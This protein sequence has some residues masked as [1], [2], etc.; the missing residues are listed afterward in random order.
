MKAKIAPLI[1]QGDSSAVPKGAHYF[2]MLDAPLVECDKT[3]GRIEAGEERWRKAQGSALVVR[4]KV[5]RDLA[6]LGQPIAADF[7]LA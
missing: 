5:R 6:R 2:R 4:P 7:P 1:N 3:E